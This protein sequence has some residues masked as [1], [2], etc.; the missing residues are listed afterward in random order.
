MSCV[1]AV[2]V[3]NTTARF[4]L[5]MVAEAA[6]P[7]LVASCE[8]T[9]RQPLTADEARIQLGQVLAELD[10]G[11]HADAAPNTDGTAPCGGSACTENAPSS[12]RAP[13]G[14][15]LAGSIL[16]CVV[17]TLTDVWHRALDAVVPGRQLV[18][19]PGLRSGIKLRFNDPSEVGS[20]RIADTVAARA[21][22]G[23]P[24]VVI[25]LGTTTN[26]EAIDA[27]GA[28]CGGIIAPG[29]T[30]G[31]QALTKAAARLPI[32]EL[33]TPDHVLGRSTREAMQSGIVLGEAARIDGLLD[34]ILHELVGGSAQTDAPAAVQSNGPAMDAGAGARDTEAVAR[35]P[36]VP[37][38]ITGEN[39]AAIAA[40]LRHRVTVDDTLT[41]R[42]LALIWQNNQRHTRAGAGK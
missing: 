30:I 40:L 17:P 28:F 29:I 35:T 32:I 14:N 5:L 27:A 41:L 7:E 12:A 4:G 18:V 23:E 6:E 21:T 38:V 34:I 37:V 22:Y 20:D 39:A 1:L 10:G 15:A 9:T 8:V 2:D 13:E 11:Q 33:R 36:D 24:A 42:G 19:G 3:G 16:S 31:A 25:D 26:F